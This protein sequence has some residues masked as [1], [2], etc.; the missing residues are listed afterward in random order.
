MVNHFFWSKSSIFC[1]VRTT[2]FCSNF[3]S[4]WSKYVSNN[5]WR[6]FNTTS[7]VSISNGNIKY[8]IVKSIFAVN[9][10]LKLFPATV[11]NANIASLKSLHTFLIKCLYYMLVKFEQSRIVQT[12][13]NFKLFDKKLSFL[14]PFL[15]K[16]LTPF[17]KT[18]L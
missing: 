2:R 11:A 12:T 3:T 15:T 14:K 18:F 13:R 4:V 16:A 10:L 1:I 7:N 5:V 6:D 17:W 9:L 8:P